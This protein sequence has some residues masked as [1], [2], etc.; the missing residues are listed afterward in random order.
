MQRMDRMRP[1]RVALL[2]AVSVASV[3][4]VAQGWD[5]GRC[6]LGVLMSSLDQVRQMA[7]VMDQSGKER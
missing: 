1:A 5:L 2:A 7:A 6:R 4:S 3:A